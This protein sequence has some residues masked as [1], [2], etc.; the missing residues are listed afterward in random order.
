MNTTDAIKH[1]A[2]PPATEYAAGIGHSTLSKLR[3]RPRITVGRLARIG[4]ELCTG[5][6]TLRDNR[7]GFIKEP[8][9]VVYAAAYADKCSSHQKSLIGL[10]IESQPRPGGKL[11]A[12]L[13]ADEIEPTITRAGSMV[14]AIVFSNEQAAQMAH[15]RPQL[16]LCVNLRGQR[17]GPSSVANVIADKPQPHLPTRRAMAC[18]PRRPHLSELPALAVAGHSHHLSA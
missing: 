7:S 15:E 11:N 3:T 17:H 10:A 8:T 2:R 4:T 1:P 12:K 14:V 6:W 9:A 13:S 16:F 5:R 18:C